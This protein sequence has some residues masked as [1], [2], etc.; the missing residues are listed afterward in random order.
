MSQSKSFVIATRVE[1]LAWTKPQLDWLDKKIIYCRKNV[2][3]L[4][5]DFGVEELY[6]VNSRF[7]GLGILF[8][9]RS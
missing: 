2:F 3:Y 6:L 1:S 9:L 4:G 5:L 8:F 7:L